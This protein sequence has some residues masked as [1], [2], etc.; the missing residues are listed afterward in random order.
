MVQHAPD[1]FGDLMVAECDAQ[2][3][4]RFMHCVQ[5]HIGVGREVVLLCHPAHVLDH[6]F[7]LAVLLAIGVEYRSGRK[8]G[9]QGLVDRGFNAMA[10]GFVMIGADR[11]GG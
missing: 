11:E 8:R 1:R 6:V 2:K 10:N 7:D 5:R 3:L 9:F 4:R